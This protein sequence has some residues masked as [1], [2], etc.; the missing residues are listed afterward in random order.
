MFLSILTFK[1]DVNFFF[2][3]ERQIPF[4]SYTKCLNKIRNVRNLSCCRRLIPAC[5]LYW[6]CMCQGLCE[7]CIFIMKPLQ[8]VQTLQDVWHI[9]YFQWHE[10]I[11]SSIQDATLL[12]VPLS[13]Y[14]S[15][16]KFLYS[17]CVWEKS[18]VIL[19]VVVC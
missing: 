6:C 1:P 12:Y 17:A 2:F 13:T 11:S 3:F 8:F 14:Y 9:W 7:V 16:Y 10:R 19:L 18:S 5:T 15:Y 4:Q